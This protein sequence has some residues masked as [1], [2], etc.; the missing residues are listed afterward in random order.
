LNIWSLLV[1]AVAVELLRVA[2]ARVAIL[3][4]QG[5]LRLWVLH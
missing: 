2:V 4:R 3:L 5:F 1:V